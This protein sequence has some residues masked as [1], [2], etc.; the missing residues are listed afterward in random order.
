MR[1]YFILP[2]LVL[3]GLT[4]LACQEQSGQSSQPKIAVVDMARLLRDSV[5]GKDGVK[6][7]EGLQS[8]MQTDLDAIQDKIEKNP[9][10]EAAMRDLQRVYAT[11]QQRMQA[12]G[13]NVVN[14][15]MDTVQRVLNA[16]RASKDYDV[17]IGADATATFNPAIDVTN[18]VMAEVDKQ[19]IEFKPLPENAVPAPA[20]A[21]QDD[22]G[23]K[24]EKTP[25]ADE[26][27][28]K[29]IKNE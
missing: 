23:K 21:E 16:Y 2:L 6:F 13:Q 25:P 3:L 29:E 28:N 10:D 5:P 9:Q 1:N 15:L 8:K 18:E 19:K 7:I 22:S 14:I 26:K 12:E 24:D 11:S 27:G 20:E 4:L 17:I